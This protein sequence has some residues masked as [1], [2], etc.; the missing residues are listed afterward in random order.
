MPP[1]CGDGRPVKVYGDINSGNCLKVKWV[2]DRFALPYSWV[3]VDTLKGETRTPEFLKLNGAGPG[4]GRGVR[5]RPDAGAVQRHHPLSGAWQRSDPCRCV[6]RG[7]DGRMAVLGAIQPRALR[8]GLPVPDVLSRQ[9]V[10]ELD[11]DKVKRGY[12]AL[13]R[14]EHSSRCR[15]F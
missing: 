3:E 4:P 10:S 2:C 9:A 1:W 11:P 6:C 13:A 12:A 8:R 7:E 5:G 15:G 14:M